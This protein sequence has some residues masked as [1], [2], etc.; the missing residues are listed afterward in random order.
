MP[1]TLSLK[2]WPTRH[3]HGKFHSSKGLRC[4]QVSHV[5]IPVLLPTLSPTPVKKRSSNLIIQHLFLP[6]FS[7]RQQCSL[8]SPPSR[9]Q[10]TVLIP[11]HLPLP[12][13]SQNRE[14]GC[15]SSSA[16]HT[17]DFRLFFSRA[18]EMTLL[19]SAASGRSPPSLPSPKAPGTNMEAARQQPR[20]HPPTPAAPWRLHPSNRRHNYNM[21]L[22]SLS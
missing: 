13:A 11:A 7:P 9:R 14:P 1:S 17:H 3:L 10:L 2:R 20:G 18:S 6:R 19:Q 4:I 8:W 22:P 5:L 16:F 12:P 21:F 15:L